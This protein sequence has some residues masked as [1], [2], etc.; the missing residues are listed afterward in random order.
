[1]RSQPP[2]CA[3][4]IFSPLIDCIAKR[5]AASNTVSLVDLQLE[6]LPLSLRYLLHISRALLQNRSVR[7]LSVARSNV[8]DDGCD[9]L[10]TTLKYLPHVDRVDFSGCF[11]TAN[12]AA[13]IGALLRYQKIVRFSEG[14]RQSLSYR[15]VQANQ[16]LG[17]KYVALN[18]NASIGDGGLRELLAVLVEDEWIS[19]V[20]M[21]Q[22]GITEHG[23]SEIVQYLQMNK[24]M[25]VFD[26]R[27]NSGVEMQTMNQMRRLMGIAVD[28][29]TVDD[30]GMNSTTTAV[31]TGKPVSMKA[32]IEQS[33]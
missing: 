33:K 12:G 16:M 13:S 20:E 27:N 5:L 32:K 11:L 19:G 7:F 2:F 25:L 24:T 8:G 6:G 28:V 26:V 22:C 23:A 1:M 29:E 4:F 3:Q 10:C 14:W 15:D 31:T 18:R 17:L 9:L 21:Q 30:D